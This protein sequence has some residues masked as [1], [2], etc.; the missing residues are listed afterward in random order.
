[1]SGIQIRVPMTAVLAQF[2]HQ[3]PE[4]TYSDDTLVLDGG[5]GTYWVENGT[6]GVQTSFEDDLLLDEAV[7]AMARFAFIGA[8]M[9][10]P[11]TKGRCFMG[12]HDRDSLEPSDQQVLVEKL[13]KDHNIEF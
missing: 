1:M 2:P 9:K 4:I 6:G 3:Q 8:K 7:R 13:L 5:D 11:R 12:D 10:G